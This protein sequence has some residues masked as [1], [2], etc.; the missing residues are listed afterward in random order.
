[1]KNCSVAKIIYSK[2]HGS[3]TT[4]FK[5]SFDNK[6]LEECPLYSVANANNDC[7]CERL[8]YY[9]KT[10][11]VKNCLNPDLTLCEKINDYPILIMGE[12]EC[13]NYCQGIL[14]LSG[15]ECH[16]DSYK[17]EQNETILTEINGDRK[18]TC[19]D[20]YY[21]VTENGRKV[22]KCLGQ[23]DECPP[24]FPKYIK[25]TKECVEECPDEKYNKK[26]GKICASS[27]PYPTIENE[28][29][30]TCKCAGKWYINENYEVICLTGG[31]PIDKELLV[32][33]TNQCV[34]TCIG[35]GF[36]V[37]S[38]KKCIIDCDSPRVK[39]SSNED[40]TFKNLATDY[41]R[42]QNTCY[43]DPNGNEVCKEEE[44]SCVGIDNLNFKFV[45]KPTK[46]CVNSCSDTYPYI[47]N[48]E[49]LLDCG[50]EHNKNDITKTCECKKLWEYDQDGKTK[51]CLTLDSCDDEYLLIKSTN[52]CY[53]G[54]KYPKS[55]P[56][57]FENI[58]YEINNC[59]S[60]LNTKYDDINEKCIC[61]NKWY[62]VD[63][64]IICLPE[65]S[66]C[67][68][69][70][71][72]L[73]YSTKK[74]IKKGD[75]PNNLYEFNYTFY[76]NCPKKT[77]KDDNSKNCICD[78]SLGSWYSNQT[79]DGRDIM[80]CSQEECPD[81]K[82]Y[83]DYKTKECKSICTAPVSYSYQGICYEKCPNLTE[84]TDANP[85]ECQLKSVDNEITLTNLEKQ[86]KENIVELYAKNNSLK[87]DNPNI[88]KKIVTTNG[89][90]EFYGVNKNDKGNT[91][92]NIQSDLSYIDISECIDKIYSAN[93]MKNN[94]DIVILKFDIKKTLSNFLINPVEYKFINSKTGKELDATV[95]EHNS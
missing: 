65:S 13:S 50:S 88:A 72:Y 34:S 18:C 56:V 6:C 52:E 87:K 43:I 48:N 47:F 75:A 23:N 27:C 51:K 24:S 49:C 16:N 35:T 86:M 95:C 63:E 26:Y 70:Y 45:I 57:L 29:D 67:P 92:Q 12:N 58:C 33:S 60:N 36:V 17:C 71:P 84:T 59:P 80:F 69:D 5:K 85:S 20:K 66:D 73:I 90:V 53:K 42:C 79:S 78:P 31:Y 21:Y 30:H 25:E 64:K 74:C 15:T 19:V 11:N 83:K 14:S 44:E 91:K 39:V 38:N 9:N 37:Y 82:P 77:K 32:E 89:T 28:S 40:P 61:V 94:E 1:M 7:I 68:S 55:S 62:K 54:D 2:Y 41:C 10:T 81:S 93:K 8:F 22:K 76:K 46:Q 3:T 4:T